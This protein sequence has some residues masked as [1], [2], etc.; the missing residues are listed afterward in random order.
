MLAFSGR[1]REDALGRLSR[2]RSIA[3]SNEAMSYAQSGINI[4]KADATKQEMRES[5]ETSNPRVINSLGAFASLYDF[6]FPEMEAPV[7]VLKME[8]PGSK[9]LLAAQHGKLASVGYDLIHHLINDTIMMGARPLA[10]QDT[11][12]CGE[13]EKDVVVALVDAMAD[14]CR[15]QKCDLVGGETSEQPRVIP[16]GSYILSAACVGVV[17]RPKIVDGSQIK[18][19]DVVLGVASNGVHTNGYT[20]VRSLL[21]RNPALAETK[22]GELTFIE[23]V[24]LPHLCY[25]L[26]LQEALQGGGICGLAHITGGGIID[27]L[28]RV[29]PSSVSAQI[30]L[31]KV[32]VLPIFQAIAKEGSVPHDD[33][34]RTFNMGVGMIIVAAKESVSQIQEA[35]NA[36]SHTVYPIGVIESGDGTVS[37]SGLL[38]LS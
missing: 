6:H 8:E 34:L 11:I 26:P 22:V 1:L 35:Y 30:D 5:L 31:S 24:L 10:I 38:A 15:K 17:D 27:N 16:N 13:L 4:D 32:E 18:E 29:L 12:I 23:Q 9:Q 21:D 28:K 25:N 14:A 7:M 33:M 3:M 19:G 36:H 37:C 2:Q 20:L